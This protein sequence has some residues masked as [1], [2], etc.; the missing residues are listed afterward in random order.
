MRRRPYDIY[1]QNIVVGVDLQR[2][3][4]LGKI[5]GRYQSTEY[6][7]EQFPGLVYRQSKPKAV[8]LIFTSGKM[9]CA[10]SKSIKDAEKFIRK[11]NKEV[12][13]GTFGRSEKEP[14]VKVSNIVASGNF[15]GY[16]SIEYIN[17]L[18]QNFPRYKS[19]YEPEQFPAA[20]VRDTKE[21]LIESS[22][23]EKKAVFL[24]F[25]SGK[26]VCTGCKSE[27]SLTTRVDDMYKALFE[28]DLIDKDTEV[29]VSA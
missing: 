1:I 13:W 10:G 24:L 28:T 16:V 7:P 15:H 4:N 3:L 8:M 27:E 11:V 25:S 2:R 18:N 26:Y 20:V 5:V 23:I 14:I 9:V 19:M 21:Y 29:A 17:R 12:I 6:R 22:F